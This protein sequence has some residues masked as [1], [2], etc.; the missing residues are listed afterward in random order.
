MEI[1]K[2]R[3]NTESNY[4]TLDAKIY[5]KMVDSSGG[6]VKSNQKIAVAPESVKSM[7]RKIAD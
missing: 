3:A 2:T 4:L 1:L 6:S 5:Q 7:C